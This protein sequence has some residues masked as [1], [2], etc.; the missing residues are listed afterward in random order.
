MYKI[1]NQ[2]NLGKFRT[3][4]D[5]T[6]DAQFGHYPPQLGTLEAGEVRQKACLSALYGQAG[7]G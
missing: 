2:T 7:S 4:I 3:K 1:F 5:A 6:L